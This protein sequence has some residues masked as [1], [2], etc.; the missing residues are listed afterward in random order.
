MQTDYVTNI[1]AARNFAFRRGVALGADWI[2]VFD[3]ST[4]VTEQMWDGLVRSTRDADKRG[5]K[6][7]YQILS[8]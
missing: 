6:C 1:N 7:V 3:G 4:L 2:F 8:Q 5:R